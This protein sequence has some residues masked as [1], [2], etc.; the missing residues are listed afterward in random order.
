MLGWIPVLQFPLF[1]IL[2]VHCVRCL[3]EL[4]TTMCLDNGLMYSI[5]LLYLKTYHAFY[6]EK[7]SHPYFNDFRLKLA[8]QESVRMAYRVVSCFI[9]VCQCHALIV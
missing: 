4:T 2:H 3:C 8:A 7:R 1:V 5:I 6:I 9:R